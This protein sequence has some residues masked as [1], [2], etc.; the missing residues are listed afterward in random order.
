MGTAQALPAAEQQSSHWP[1]TGIRI[2][3]GAVWLVDA[4]LKWTGHFRHGYIDHLK[5]G[6]EG[7][8]GWLDPW[9]R[10]WIDLQTPAPHFWAYLVA[11]IETLIALAVLIGF[12]RKLT[13]L[14]AIVFSLLIWMT[15]EGFG[16]PYMGASADVDVSAGIIYALVFASLLAFNYYLDPSPWS[17][18]YHLE[19]RLSW[20][21]RIAEVGPHHRGPRPGSQ[22]IAQPA[23]PI[24]ERSRRLAT[25]AQHRTGVKP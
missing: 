25:P 3:F 20:W 14:S 24:S 16:G 10:F 12:A 2:A 6:S 11:I 4:A 5:E 15:A 1:K 18:D 22:A 19:K 23:A 13:Y 17:A 21:Y 8:P 9:F 7:R